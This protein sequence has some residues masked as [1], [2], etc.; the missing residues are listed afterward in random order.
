MAE[1]TK[2]LYFEDPYRTEFEALVIERLTYQG[3]PALILDRTCFYPEGGGQPA[4]R[5]TLNGIA[6]VHVI[7]EQSQILH[8][9]EKGISGNK[10]KGKIEWPRRF[11]HMQQ[12]AGQHVL[13]QCFVQLQEAETRS[14]HL[15]EKAS[16]LEIDLRNIDEE[17]IERI[18]RLANEIVFRDKEIK[19]RFFREEEIGSVPLRRPPQKQGEIRVVEVAEFDYTAC[20]G[21]HPHRTGEIGLIKI[22]RWDRIRDNVRLEFLCGGRA[23]EDYIRKNRDLRELSNRLTVDDKEILGAYEKLVFDLKIQKKA[24]RRLLEGLVRYEAEE[25]I[26]KARDKI[27]QEIFKEKT[28][29][30]VR[31]LALAIIRKGDFVVLFGVRGGERVHIFLARSENL[32]MDLR[33][34][35][36]LVSPLIDGK[37]GGRPSLV[38][39]AGEKKE[40]L[41][42]ALEKAYT[43]LSSKKS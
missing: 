21:T 43:Y 31:S 17:E 13:S 29:E 28:P 42:A 8:V 20:G 19:T 39:I 10:V 27:I 14:F 41:G 25:I 4:D 7:E 36:P 33:E 30:E 5:G 26:G 37:G 2:R 38:E 12:H 22:L 9:L 3:Q 16:T 6:V 11:D 18:E 1:E 40:N 32:D 24:N 34:L 23:L 35:V 15:G